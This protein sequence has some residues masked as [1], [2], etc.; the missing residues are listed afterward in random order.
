MANKANAETLRAF[1]WQLS[2]A[3][4]EIDPDKRAGMELAA[5]APAEWLD[6]LREIDSRYAAPDMVAAR[7]ALAA[8]GRL[9]RAAA[10]L[11]RIALEEANGV[12]VAWDHARREPIMGLR[13][14]DHERHEKTRERARNRIGEAVAALMGDAAE[15]VEIETSGDPRGAVVKVWRRGERD[16]GSPVFTL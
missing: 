4:V 12:P 16:T 8:A 10:A 14:E 5:R 15:A 13:P 7:D 1:L 9:R 6:R 3:R 2:A 11:D